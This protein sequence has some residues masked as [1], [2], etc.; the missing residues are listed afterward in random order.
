MKILLL[1]LLV[2]CAPVRNLVAD[3][4]IARAQCEV[5]TMRCNENVPEMC[6]RADNV[7][8]WYPLH[9]RRADGT[10]APCANRCVVDGVVATAH[11]SD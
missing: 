1:C 6:I 9:P 5:G 11:C 10:A 8:R 7:P 2:A 4:T 3:Q